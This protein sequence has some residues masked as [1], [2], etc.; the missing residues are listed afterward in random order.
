ME[1][2]YIEAF[3]ANPKKVWQMLVELGDI[4]AQARPNSAHLALAQLESMGHLKA[5][6]TQN[7]DGLHQEAGSNNVIEF[8]GN[9]QRLICSS[10]KK[11]YS[12]DV[13]NPSDLPPRC[14]CQ[15]ILKPD[16][17]FFGEPIPIEASQK[18]FQESRSCDI[19]LVVGTYAMV[20]PASQI[21]FLAKQQGAVIVEINLEKTHLSETI[22]DFVMEASASQALSTILG[23][24]RSFH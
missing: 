17:V 18:A 20:A 2:A 21:P 8:H 7:I 3:M 22:S 16:V 13:V 1:F 11:I 9:G 12:R 10:C 4:V 14:S 23:F 5:V 19:M 15:G 24:M 6:I